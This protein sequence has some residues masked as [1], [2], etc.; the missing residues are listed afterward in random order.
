MQPPRSKGG[1]PTTYR[2]VTRS[3]TRRQQRNSLPLPEDLAMEIF[4]RLPPKSISRFRCA[5]KLFS[6]MLRSQYFTDS[7]LT[8]SCARPRLLFACE[9]HGE[10]IFISSPQPENPEENSHVVASN[11][12]AC[13]PRSNGFYG[14]TNGFFCYEPDLFFKGLKKPVRVPVICNPST[15]QSLT[16]PRLISKK[17]Y[18]VKSYLGYEPMKKEFKVL[19]MTKSFVSDEW[20]SM[21]HQVLTLGTEKLT[22]RLVECCIPH[23]HS[24]KWICISGVLYYAARAVGSYEN[25]MVVCFDLRSEKFSSVKF[26]K[27]M[28][29]STTLVNYDGKLGLLMSGDSHDNVTRATSS[30]ELWVL[31]DAAKDEWSNHVYVL[32]PSWGEVVVAEMTMCI[33]GMVG[34]NE[35]V[36]SP[37]YQRVP[38]Y[39]IYFN[40]ER[41]TITQVGIQGLEAFQGK[42]FDTY[43]NYVENVKFL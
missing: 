9:D 43:V 5:S 42:S 15:G 41:K 29:G 34:T 24:C 19:S 12:L 13:F 39:V 22:W 2:G 4:S 30:L 10:F 31:V 8:R 16:T 11:P 6:S 25:A 36:L 21:E 32:P 38:Y 1:A 7:F 18:G 20:N 14:C 3:M 27:A 23:V 40:V 28:P 35:I 37:R 26:G 17:R 33:A